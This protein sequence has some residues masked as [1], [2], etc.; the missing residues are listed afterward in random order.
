MRRRVLLAFERGRAR[1]G[2]GAPARAAD[3]RH[4]RR[5]ADRRRAGRRAGGNRAAVAGEGLPS[6]RSEL[7]AN[8]PDRR[9]ARR[10]AAVSG[11]APRRR[12]PRP[13]AARR[14]GAHGHARDAHRSRRRARQ[15]R[16]ASRRRP[17]SGRRAWRR[18]RSARRSASRWIARAASSSGPI[19]TIPGHPEVFVIGDLA[20][21]AGPAGRPA[22]GRCAGGDADGR[23]C[24]PQHRP[25]GGRTAAARVHVSQSRRHGHDRPRLGGRRP[26]D[27]Q[28][29][30][31][32]SAGSRGCSC[33]S[34]I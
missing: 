20:S 17:F 24:V 28:A 25:R 19:S 34:S 5:R 12:A 22:A 15:A 7:V 10:P 33:T 29:D 4:R 8:H 26:P 27:D 3:V 9:R 11:A 30:R 21:L 14:R 18:R 23:P 6:F 1:T 32:R 31:H 16:N 13:G 2:P